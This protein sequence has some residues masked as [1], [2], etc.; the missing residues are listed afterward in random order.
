MVLILVKIKQFTVLILDNAY[1][2]AGHYWTSINK[3]LFKKEVIVV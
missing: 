3:S 1:V 2:R